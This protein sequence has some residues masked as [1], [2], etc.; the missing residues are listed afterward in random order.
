MILKKILRKDG[1]HGRLIIM[2]ELESG[3]Y[4]VGTN[5]EEGHPIAG[6]CTLFKDVIMA[7]KWFEDRVDFI[8]DLH[9][10]SKVF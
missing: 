1:S 9:R 10:K 6:K 8:S 2:G 7:F 3:E 4:V 5:L